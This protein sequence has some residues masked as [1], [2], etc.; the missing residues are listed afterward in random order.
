M[1]P[2]VH[3]SLHWGYEDPAGADGHDDDARMAVF[4]RV[5]SQLDERIARFA[6]AHAPPGGLMDSSTCSATPM[7]ATPR[8]GTAP[9]PHDR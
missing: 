6:A 7:P 2:G 9:M 3:E 4:R 1:F 8:P 5:F